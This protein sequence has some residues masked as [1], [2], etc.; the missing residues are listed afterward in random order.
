MA[1][2]ETVYV[3]TMVLS[4]VTR[5]NGKIGY[6]PPRVE[7][8]FTAAAAVNPALAGL[9]AARATRLMTLFGVPS[10]SAPPVPSY[11]PRIG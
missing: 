3:G 4:L 2:G 6:A 11:V 10:P 7:N 8:E 1:A 9:G 5:P